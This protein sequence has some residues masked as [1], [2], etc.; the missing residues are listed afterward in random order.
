MSAL[1]SPEMLSQARASQKEFEEKLPEA[2]ATAFVSYSLARPAIDRTPDPLEKKLL[3]SVVASGL[4]LLGAA[5]SKGL[6]AKDD[7]TAAVFN[8]GHEI[9]LE[10]AS[11]AR[12]MGNLYSFYEACHGP[13]DSN[14]VG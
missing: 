11:H 4:H 14:P 2:C 13:H 9:G 6:L 12:L 7:L 5:I 10:P 3:Y 1:I 8:K